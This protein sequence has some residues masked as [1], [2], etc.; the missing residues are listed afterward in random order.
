ML[1]ELGAFSEGAVRSIED[2]I[3]ANVPELDILDHWTARNDGRSSTITGDIAVIPT[4]SSH[5][6]ECNG[7]I[8]GE[9]SQIGL[10]PPRN[11]PARVDVL[12]TPGVRS[13]R[14]KQTTLQKNSSDQLR[15]ALP[16]G[17]LSQ[18]GRLS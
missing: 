12:P 11:S 5:G 16:R 4:P 18:L 15:L 6:H 9:R 7:L 10:C 3:L 1:L 2:A 17:H 13:W 14:Q 8:D